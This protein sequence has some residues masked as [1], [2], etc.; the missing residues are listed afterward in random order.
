MAPVA[1]TITWDGRD[2][3]AAV[4][5]GFRLM[6]AEDHIVGI[7]YAHPK[8]MKQIVLTMPDEVSFDF[9]PEGIG[10]LRTAYLKFRP[11]PTDDEIRMVSQDGSTVVKILG[12][13][14]GG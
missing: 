2:V 10:M 12:P 14:R 4:M 13:S 6:E 8:V 1:R 9:I 11:M 5:G 3:K 7:I